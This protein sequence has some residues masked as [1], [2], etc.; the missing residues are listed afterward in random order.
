MDL[1]GSGWDQVARSCGHGIVPS[2]FIEVWGISSLTEQLL[3][4]Q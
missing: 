2:G 4:F 1:P 3:V